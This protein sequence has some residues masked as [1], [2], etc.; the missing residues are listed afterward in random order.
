MS[1]QSRTDDCPVTPRDHIVGLFQKRNDDAYQ[2]IGTVT[3]ED[4]TRILTM[5]PSSGSAS[6]VLTRKQNLGAGDDNDSHITEECFLLLKEENE[7][8]KRRLED[9][10]SQ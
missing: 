2:L 3:G 10:E 5:L 9:L 6:T 1:Q 8:L 4:A 7:S